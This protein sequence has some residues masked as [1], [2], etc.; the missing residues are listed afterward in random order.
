MGKSLD[1]MPKALIDFYKSHKMLKNRQQQRQKL[2][3]QLNNISK[4]KNNNNSDTL[5]Y[6]QQ[7]APVIRSLQIKNGVIETLKNK[8][9]QQ[10][11]KLQQQ[12]IPIPSQQTIKNV[13]EQLKKQQQQQ[14]KPQ[15][16]KTPAKT[17]GW[18]W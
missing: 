11:S 17:F 14:N 1:N 10:K 7:T 9:I 13:V 6:Y 4:V 18:K 12:N 8:I 2:Q 16:K 3:V 15:Q 5:R